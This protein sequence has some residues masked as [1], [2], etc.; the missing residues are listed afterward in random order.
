MRTLPLILLCACATPRPTVAL[1]ADDTDLVPAAD[2]DAR[3]TDTAIDD[4]ASAVDT[5]PTFWTTTQAEDT[6]R[7]A[8]PGLL[9]L[10]ESEWTPDVLVLRDGAMAWGRLDVREL[11]A[12][13]YVAQPDHV[14]LAER[15][16]E[17]TTLPDLFDRLTEPQAWWSDWELGQQPGW[18]T[19]R[20]VFEHHL[21]AVQVVRLG[22]RDLGYGHVGGAVDVY[23]IGASSD[24]DLVMVHVV[25]VET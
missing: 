10:S 12:P 2:T 22:E 21:G 24:G 20:D 3:S 6:L 15:V 25:S 7:A 5:A 16:V 17:T 23:V 11:L 1:T 8:T 14:P 9:F 4:T 13:V 18:I 19:V